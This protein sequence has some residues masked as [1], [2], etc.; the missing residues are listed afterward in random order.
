MEKMFRLTYFQDDD[1]GKL[2][3]K[4]LGIYSS[5]NKVNRALKR[6]KVLSGFKDNITRFHVFEEILDK[7]HWNE[8]FIFK[9]DHYYEIEDKEFHRLIGLYT[10]FERAKETIE[11]YKLLPG[12]KEYPYDFY[13][14]VYEIN[15]GHWEEGFV[16]EY[17]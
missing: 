4:V 2:V 10:S 9:L 15:K 7:S 16:T 12:F 11:N 13:L 5:K 17:Y 8:G 14:E 6:Y 1:K 3:C